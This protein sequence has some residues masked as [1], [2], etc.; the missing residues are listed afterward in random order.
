MYVWCVCVFFILIHKSF[1]ILNI[2]IDRVR[3]RERERE[4]NMFIGFLYYTNLDM[5]INSLVW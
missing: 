3:E 4:N 5:Y 2:R 1:F